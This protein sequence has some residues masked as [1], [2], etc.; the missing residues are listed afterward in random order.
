MIFGFE[1]ARY[2]KNKFKSYFWFWKNKRDLKNKFKSDFY[3]HK[4]TN[5]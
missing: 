1:K 2:L 4:A 3:L 5:L